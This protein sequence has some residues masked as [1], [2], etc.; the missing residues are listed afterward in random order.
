MV[1]SKIYF[2]HIILLVLKWLQVSNIEQLRQ[3]LTILFDDNANMSTAN[4]LRTYRAN[5]LK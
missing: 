2:L 4:K 5:T 3:G 1:F